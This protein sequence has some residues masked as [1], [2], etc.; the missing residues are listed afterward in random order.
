MPRLSTEPGSSDPPQADVHPAV[1]EDQHKRD[2][3]DRST[4]LIDGADTAGNT[5]ATSEAPSRKKAGAGTRTHWLTRLDAIARVSTPP[6]TSRI[7][8][9]GSMSST[10]DADP[11]RSRRAR[12]A[13]DGH[14]GQNRPTVLPPRPGRATMTAPTADIQKI[15]ASQ[16]TRTSNPNSGTLLHRQHQSGDREEDAAPATSADRARRSRVGSAG[17]RTTGIPPALDGPAAIVTATP[18]R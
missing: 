13:V 12:R 10:T 9:I 16:G 17:S 15:I 18:H 11:A 7:P 1:E 14:R 8:R 6:T 4:V 5:L 3:H 2:G